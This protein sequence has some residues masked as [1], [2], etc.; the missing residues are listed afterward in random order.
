[1]KLLV[2]EDN[3]FLAD[4][5]KR[6][7]GKSFVIDVAWTG[8]EGLSQAKAKHHSMI[9]LDLNL[10]DMNGYD[11]CKQIRETGNDV[12]LLILTGVKDLTSRVE[13]L[14]IG[15]DDYLTKPFSVAE[16]QARIKALLRRAPAKYG[17]DN[18]SVHDLVINPNRRQV[19]RGGKSIQLRR[20]EFDILEYLVRNQGKAVSR[21]MIFSHVWESKSENWSNTVDVHIKYLRDKIDRPFENQ[22][23]KTAYGVGY[24]VDD[25]N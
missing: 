19:I 22:L 17:P 11:I 16:L 5:L 4:S 20:K 1:M 2:I 6:H 15:A 8:K 7:L 23:I 3:R 9:I 14:N 18:L 12:P 13:L 10:P 25:I 24:M 21:K